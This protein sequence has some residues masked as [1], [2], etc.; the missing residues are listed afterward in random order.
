MDRGDRVLATAISMGRLYNL[1]AVHIPL[2]SSTSKSHSG[3]KTFDYTS[4]SITSSLKS[5]MTFGPSW[6]AIG[7]QEVKTSGP[8][9][10]Y[11]GIVLTVKL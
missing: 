9:L 4:T 1:K 10:I 2:T 7:K 11:T 3:V 5:Y 8:A 6:E